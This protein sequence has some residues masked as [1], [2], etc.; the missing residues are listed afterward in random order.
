VPKFYFLAW[1]EAHLDIYKSAFKMLEIT[2]DSNVRI[3][4]WLE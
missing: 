4:A 1:P 2:V 3:S